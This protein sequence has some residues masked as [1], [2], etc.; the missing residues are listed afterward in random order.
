MEWQIRNYEQSPYYNYPTTGY[1]TGINLNDIIAPE[2]PFTKLL[3]DDNLDIGDGPYTIKDIWDGTSII[4]ASYT[5]DTILGLIQKTTTDFKSTDIAD[6][7]CIYDNK[8]IVFC[9]F[10]L[11]IFLF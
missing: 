1:E 10:S 6:S 2:A 11:M 7:S 4:N 9:V 8:Y 5:Y 3:F